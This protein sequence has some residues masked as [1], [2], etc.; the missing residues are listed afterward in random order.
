MR[1]GP[2]KQKLQ[3]EPV[4][5]ILLP[6]AI[7]VKGVARASCTFVRYAIKIGVRKWKGEWPEEAKKK[8]KKKKNFCKPGENN[9]PPFQ[10]LC[11]Y[12]TPVRWKAQ[13]QCVKL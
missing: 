13:L 3:S 8:K 9:C 2:N 5:T 6:Q 4:L 10:V 11:L 12:M 7:P 1:S